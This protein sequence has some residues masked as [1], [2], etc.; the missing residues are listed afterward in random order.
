M[1]AECLCKCMYVLAYVCM[2][3]CVYLSCT[4]EHNR[5]ETGL[6][7]HP[8]HTDER[9]HPSYLSFVLVHLN[10]RYFA[11]Y[12][13][14]PP[15]TILT[16]AYDREIPLGLYPVFLSISD[17]YCAFRIEG[18]SPWKAQAIR[19]PWLLLRRPSV[20]RD[21]SSLNEPGGVLYNSHTKDRYRH[22]YTG[23]VS[24]P[25][26]GADRFGSRACDWRLA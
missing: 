2:C 26:T 9:S 8:V 25:S 1:C 21:R 23:S 4:Y 14:S 12:L 18:F 15:N 22:R 5:A 16:F 7:S 17:Q 24:G 6:R 20:L 11:L 13:H 19:R 10:I 3:M